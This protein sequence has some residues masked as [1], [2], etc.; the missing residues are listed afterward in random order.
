MSLIAGIAAGMTIVVMIRFI[1]LLDVPHPFI[2]RFK[3][4]DNGFAVCH[5]RSYL[6]I[7][8]SPER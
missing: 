6:F 3:V 7:A 4:I 8:A 2:D 5:D 1:S